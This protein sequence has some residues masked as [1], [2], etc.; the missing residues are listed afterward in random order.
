[1]VRR[2]KGPE[3]LLLIS[4]KETCC[5]ITNRLKTTWLG[6]IQWYLYNHENTIQRNRHVRQNNF[7]CIGIS[8]LKNLKGE[9]MSR[10]LRINEIQF[11]QDS[12]KLYIIYKM[13][14]NNLN[15][16]IFSILYEGYLKL[17]SNKLDSNYNLLEFP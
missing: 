16:Q 1:M 3:K 10:C 4:G 13:E 12:I 8:T 5:Y 9:T 17:V 6:A 2:Q 7:I 15:K 11:F 14:D